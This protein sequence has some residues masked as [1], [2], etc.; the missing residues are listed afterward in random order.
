VNQQ[1]DQA[2]QNLE[3]FNLQIKLAERDAALAAL[4][5]KLDKANQINERIETLLQINLTLSK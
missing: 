2:K 1:L 5:G 4:E 3:Q